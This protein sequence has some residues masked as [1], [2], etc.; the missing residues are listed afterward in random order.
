MSK[1]L[2]V[3]IILIC[4]ISFFFS[5]FKKTEAPPCIN[6]D[7][8]AVTYNA[9]SILKTGRDEYGKLL[10]LR[11]QSFGDFKMPLQFYLSIPAVVMFGLSDFSVRLTNSL[12]ALVFP[13]A[14]YFLAFELFSKKRIALLASFLS[15][16]SFG[17]LMLS[18]QQ[19]EGYTAGLLITL[20]SLFFLKIL[21]KQ[22]T[23]NCLL[24]F[25]VLFL[26]LFTYH[27]SRIFAFF[28]L[29]YGII[30]FLIKKIKAR[31]F[32]LIFIIVL[33]LFFVTDIIYSPT[34]IKNLLFFNNI[35]L[36][37]TV[38][39]LRGEGGTRLLYNKATISAFNL[40]YEYLKY[41]SPQFLAIDGD[42]NVKFGFKNLPPLTPVVY[43]FIFIGLYFLFKKKEKERFFILM[44]FLVAPF[45]ASLSWAG[46][47]LTRSYFILIPAIIISAYGFYNFI[48]S[49]HPRFKT[50]ILLS[51]IL[52]QFIFLFYS[53]DFYFNHYSKRAIVIRAWQCG[54]KEMAEYVEKNYSRFDHFY[55]T[56]QNGQPYIF[57]LFYL[58]YPPQKY[59]AQANLSTSDKYGF[60]QVE[61]FDKFNFNFKQPKDLEEK[62]VTIG[63]PEDFSSSY[64]T[65]IKEIKI[66]TEKMFW[67]Y[68]NP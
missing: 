18:R 23:K 36:G 6:T 67:I 39:E 29:S 45:G 16:T 34:R 5:Y 61:H 14:V 47:S 28:F 64:A 22:S 46:S 37:L 58:K 19:H 2:L 60:G 48:R 44:L 50:L 13:L 49:L 31:N 65:N 43:I 38:S 25:L 7:E 32:F 24:F 3:V 30:Y 21:K 9:Y 55:I 66:G 59:Q 68:E 63:F 52:L 27:S 51:L 4:L 20:T 62:A 41:F 11:F 54:N 53:W 8:A 1:K 56:K 57:L 26:S 15:A 42:E 33:S 12:I 35:G 17:I 10:P 40:T